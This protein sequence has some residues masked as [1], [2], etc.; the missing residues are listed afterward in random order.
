MLFCP[1]KLLHNVILARQELSPITTPLGKRYAHQGCLQFPNK[2]A[3]KASQRYQENRE[4]ECGRV[5]ESGRH[6][7]QVRQK[8][9]IRQHLGGNVVKHN[10]EKPRK[11]THQEAEKRKPRPI[12]K[13]LELSWRGMTMMILDQECRL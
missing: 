3:Q 6:S 1:L 9:G 4:Q 7:E 13:G 10:V 5:E 8:D 11:G 2:V 12:T